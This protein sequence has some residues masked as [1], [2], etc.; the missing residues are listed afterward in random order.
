MQ[1]IKLVVKFKKTGLMRY[2]SHLDFIRSIYRALR[3]AN[4]PFIFTEGYNPR[5]KVK[6]GQALK[7]GVEGEIETEFFLKTKIE[8]SEFQVRMKKELNQD[9]RMMEIN[10]A[11]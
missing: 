8:L 5:P 9:L 10:Y 4:I 7:L 3:R 2:I 6:F 11:E 1:S